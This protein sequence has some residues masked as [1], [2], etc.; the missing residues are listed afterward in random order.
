MVAAELTFNMPTAGILLAT[1]YSEVHNYSVY[2]TADNKLAICNLL[3]NTTA[4]FQNTATIFEDRGTET[5]A[6]LN[7]S[8]TDYRSKKR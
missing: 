4:R 5:C 6:A 1:I 8:N 7:Q 2:K 3:A